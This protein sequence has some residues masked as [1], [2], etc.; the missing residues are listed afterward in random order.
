M[1]TARRSAPELRQRLED[2]TAGE[3]KKAMDTAPT[4]WATMCD[5]IRPYMLC[6][7]YL[8][9]IRRPRFSFSQA[10]LSPT[11]R[12]GTQNFEKGLDKPAK[13]CYYVFGNS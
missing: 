9:H 8:Y 1:P 5:R 11:M 10:V 4:I 7:G 12:A 3:K 13:M 6:I 2:L